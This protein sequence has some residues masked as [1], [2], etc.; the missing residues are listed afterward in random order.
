[1]TGDE[2]IK[3]NALHLDTRVAE[4]QQV[5][6]D[7]VACLGNI[8]IFKDGSQGIQNRFDVEVVGSALLVP[9]RLE[10]RPA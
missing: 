9:P 5:V 4:N 8:W 10:A 6:F 7:V 3:G 2:G 1:M